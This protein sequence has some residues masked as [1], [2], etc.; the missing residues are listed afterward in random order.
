MLIRDLT[1]S[2]NEVAELSHKVHNTAEGKLAVA[3]ERDKPHITDIVVNACWE[4]RTVFL[5]GAVP[6]DIGVGGG[7]HFVA[8]AAHDFYVD[9][10][11]VAVRERV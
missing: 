8:P 3:F 9:T 4:R 7:E 5:M 1:N 2:G 6:A 11:D 10:I